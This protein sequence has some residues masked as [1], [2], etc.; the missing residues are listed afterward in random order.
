MGAMLGAAAMLIV[1]ATN[2]I[3]LRPGIGGGRIGRTGTD[4]ERYFG[5]PITAVAEL[6][7]S[8]D[9][10]LASAI[11]KVAPFYRPGNEMKL[12]VRRIGAFAAAMN[13]IFAVGVAIGIS[14]IFPPYEAA[15][16]EAGIVAIVICAFI[17]RFG[18]YFGSHL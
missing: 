3:C 4:F 14:A 8:D 6:W 15:R 9:P 11:L 16:S 12:S 2:F 10:E 5:W 18:R 17:F 13:T 1:A 7:Q